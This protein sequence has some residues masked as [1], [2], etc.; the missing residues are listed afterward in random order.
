MQIINGYFEIVLPI[1]DANDNI[2]LTGSNNWQA[3]IDGNGYVT[4]KM[5]SFINSA[6]VIGHRMTLKKLWRMT[7]VVHLLDPSDNLPQYVFDG[8]D[9]KCEKFP[10]VLPAVFPG[11]KQGGIRG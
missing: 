9:V 11:V 4:W 3:K 1:L 5:C 10:A 6:L 8:A 2:L 7:F